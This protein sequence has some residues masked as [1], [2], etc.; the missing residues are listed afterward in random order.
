[1]DQEQVNTWIQNWM[2]EHTDPENPDDLLDPKHLRIGAVSILQFAKDAGLI[3]L[4]A[5][6]L[7][8]CLIVQRIHPELNVDHS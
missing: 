5:Y 3:S 4:D 1:M 8:L 2:D 7:G 6:N